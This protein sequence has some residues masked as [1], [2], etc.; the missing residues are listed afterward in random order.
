[1]VDDP[2]ASES[3]TVNGN[4]DG[5]VNGSTVQLKYDSGTEV[6]TGGKNSTKSSPLH[7]ASRLSLPLS[8]IIASSSQ[9]ELLIS[10][11]D[12]EEGHGQNKN[13]DARENVDGSGLAS[14]KPLPTSTVPLSQ[15]E[16]DVSVTISIYTYI[17]HIF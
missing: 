8:T 5:G 17:I 10:L 9:E 13:Q 7:P 3:S 12:G 15:K 14:I 2:P 11:E 16:E 1:M 4:G 6:E